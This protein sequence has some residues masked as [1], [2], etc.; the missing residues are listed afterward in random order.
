MNNRTL[1]GL[2]LV[3]VSAA[4]SA[5]NTAV[6][7]PSVTQ[8]LQTAASSKGVTDLSIVARADGGL[9]VTGK[10]SGNPFALRVPA[11]WNGSSVLNAHG[12]VTP[13][14]PESVPDPATDPSIGLLTTVYAQGY[15]AANTAYAKTG[16][17]VKEGIDANKALRDFLDAAGSKLE[18]MTGISMGGNIT[19]GLVEKYPNDFAG[20]MPYCGVVAGWRA[21]QR[22]LLDFRVVYD[23]YTKGTV[24][25]LPG[26]GDAVTYRADYTYPAVQASVIGLFTAA[27]KGDA[28]ARSILAQ[29][30]KVTGVPADVVSYLTPLAGSSYGLQDYLS[31]AGGNGYT[32]LGKVYSGSADDAALNAGVQRI[33]ATPAGSA[34]LDANYTPTGKFSAKMLSFHNTVDPLVPY[35]FE[36]EFASVVAAAKNS[37]NL[38]QQT[39]DANPANPADPGKGGPTHCYFTP[40]QVSA[41]WNELRN[42]VE[43]DVRPPDGANITNVK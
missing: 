32:N 10:L 22:F 27:A 15:L 12:Y 2:A 14:Q 26:N 16:Y 43:K 11:N 3:A 37:D 6:T 13:G 1:T 24:Y 41:A 8:R 20:A 35:S 38:V 18:Y 21:E 29:V 31:T 23:Y 39:V 34:Y 28:A 36:P 40:T 7:P 9:N 30:S 5:C 17:A 25:A 19:V 33:T 4:L 42:W